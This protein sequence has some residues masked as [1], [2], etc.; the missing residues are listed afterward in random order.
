MPKEG[1]TPLDHVPRVGDLAAASQDPVY[2]AKEDP[3]GKALGLM[4]EHDYS[5]LPVMR[6]SG[7]GKS[8]SSGTRLDG[9]ISWRSVGEA[10]ALGKE[11]KFVSHC[12]KAKV[13][14]L[15]PETRLTAAIELV[16]REQ[17]VMIERRD[18]KVTG[19]VTLTDLTSEY[20]KTTECFNLVGQIEGY[21]RGLLKKHA[22][23]QDYA[24]ARSKNP[25]GSKAGIAKQP[26]DLVFSEYITVLTRDEVWRS[27]GLRID[28]GEFIRL[29]DRVREIRNQVMHFDPRR[30]DAAVTT[31]LR[32]AAR[33]LGKVHSANG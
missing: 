16:I 28:Q 13:P 8:S 20:L 3:I 6:V 17:F 30:D 10:F 4:I 27:M 29:L 26:S 7:R 1:S 32:K 18:G 2:V 25:G 14:T 31:E 22:T 33:M 9:Y 15:T 24:H 5:Q 23:S 19:P 11:P 21:I 12:M